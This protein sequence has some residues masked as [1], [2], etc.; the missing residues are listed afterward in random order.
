MTRFI[1]WRKVGIAFGFG[2][3]L[4]VPFLLMRP[5]SDAACYALAGIA[6]TALGA[7]AVSKFAGRGRDADS[8]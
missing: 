3:L 5:L 7:N 6:G 4:V 8:G 1:G 2:F